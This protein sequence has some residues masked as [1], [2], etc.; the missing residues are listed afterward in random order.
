MI[1]IW[2]ERTPYHEIRIIE[3]S[4]AEGRQGRFR[5]LQFADGAEQ[6]V[7]DLDEPGR[8]VLAYPRAL[9]QLLA[10]CENN[11]P[12]VFMIGHGA[13]TIAGYYASSPHVSFISV[14]L[15]ERLAQLS[16]DFFGYSG[17]E[18]RVGEGREELSKQAEDSLDCIIVD[19]F[20]AK[21][22]PRQLIS[23]PFVQLAKSRLRASGLLLYNVGGRKCNDR[24]MDAMYATLAASYTYV[25]VF[26]PAAT[27]VDEVTNILFAASD[28]PLAFDIAELAG[29]QP[30]DMQAGHLIYDR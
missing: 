21:G 17:P 24:L 9:I 23:L 25:E 26:A 1:E 20:S 15:D 29:F 22:T 8:I 30:I 16:R 5:V 28:F 3:T 6:G 2:R 7:V 11:S 19:A 18:V 4:Y 13:G 27:S 10:C 14:E 12:E